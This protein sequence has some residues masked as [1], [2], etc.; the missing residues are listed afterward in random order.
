MPFSYRDWIFG[1]KVFCCCLPVRFGVI[2]MSALGILVA[3]LLSIV[4]WFEVSAMANMTP[5]EKAAFV[6]AGIIE[7]L[8]F[9]GSILGFVGAIV[10]KQLFL[11][12]YAYFLY[13]HFF[14]NVGAA[15]YL[16]VMLGKF[17]DNAS[18]V[19]CDETITDGGARE[20]CQGL[21][22]V[23]TTV[24][25]VIA[26]VVLFLEGYGA[27]IITR[28]LNLVK[29]EKRMLRESKRHTDSAFSLQPLTRSFY[30]TSNDSRIYSPLNQQE[31]VYDPY[32]DA[33]LPGRPGHSRQVSEGQEF[34]P[35]REA[36]R[37]AGPSHSRF[38]TDQTFVDAPEDPFRPAPPIEAGYGGGFWTH[39]DISE[40]EKGRLSRT[41][42]E[43]PEASIVIRVEDLS[44]D[45]RARRRSEIKTPYGPPPS[46]E[47]EIDTLPQYVAF[48][49]PTH[50]P[51]SIP[52]PTKQQ[53][54][55]DGNLLR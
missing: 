44:D 14:L 24:Y 20:D 4:L 27:I 55:D 10:R 49:S 16:F 30:G 31:H 19:A 15:A 6:I 35:Y 7:T 1:G 25:I 52:M 8:L 11:Q 53:S 50:T 28:Y 47:P 45:E 46:E 17:Q 38:T 22:R 9:I 51:E 2:S 37:S 13:V 48:P 36:V 32:L 3:G 41:E 12:T 42:S 26:S 39:R 29:K 5:G 40:E 18:R 43:N 21:L 34:D 23:T 54:E 33:Q